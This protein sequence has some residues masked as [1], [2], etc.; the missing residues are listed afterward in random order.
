MAL[1]PALLGAPA[2]HA[3]AQESDPESAPQT[4]VVPRVVVT[5]TFTDNIRLDRAALKKAEQITEI[6]SGI[7]VSRPT[8]PLKG[9][10]DYAVSGITYAQGSHSDEVRRALTAAGELEVVDRWLVVDANANIAQQAVS[11]FGTQSSQNTYSPGNRAEVVRYRVSPHMQGRVG[12][13]LRYAL[14]YSR[15]GTESDAVGAADVFTSDASLLVEGDHAVGNLGWVVD[16]SHSEMD[17]STGRRTESDHLSLG[18]SYFLTPQL[19]VVAKVGREGDNYNTIDKQFDDTSEVGLLWAPSARTQ[20]LA[21]RSTHS[22]GD[23]HTLSF[24]HRSALTELRLSDSRAVT[25]LPGTLAPQGTPTNPVPAV[26]P[27]VSDYLTAA[28]TLQRRQELA[29]TLLGSRST[30]TLAATQSDNR[31]IDTLS[32]ALDD[33]AG[34]EVRQTGTS[35][36]FSHRLALALVL[37]VLALQQRTTGRASQSDNWLRELS[38]SLTSKFGKKGAAGMALRRSSFEGTSPY[39]EAVLTLYLTLTF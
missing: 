22:Y 32:T 33:L 24:S 15:S 2:S 5:E 25:A 17:Y 31:R 35:A 16:A 37:S 12:E 27:V 20:L 36:S 10:L 21:S 38:V 4:L 29:L 14:R 39:D 28:A 1:V 3:Q 8:G 18:L 34:S 30:V 11:A 13:L 6:S 19:S 9:T 23:S 7:S 26:L